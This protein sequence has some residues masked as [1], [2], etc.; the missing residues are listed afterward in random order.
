MK[1][2]IKITDRSQQKQWFYCRHLLFGD[3]F[4]I[5]LQNG[6][7]ILI[8]KDFFFLLLC[9]MFTFNSFCLCCLN[10]LT[11]GRT[12][13]IL[14]FYSVFFSSMWCQNKHN[15]VLQY[16]KYEGKRRKKKQQERKEELNFLDMKNRF[17]HSQPPTTERDERK[18]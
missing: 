17:F 7:L 3:K 8:L 5:P 11:R 15:M 1:I 2:A 9:Q 4:F 14:C 18:R 10:T 6:C 13:R 16:R 12:S